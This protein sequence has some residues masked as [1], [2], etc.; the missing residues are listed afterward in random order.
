MNCVTMFLRNVR[1]YA[2]YLVGLPLPP[3]PASAPAVGTN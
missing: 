2:L 3:E 1:Y